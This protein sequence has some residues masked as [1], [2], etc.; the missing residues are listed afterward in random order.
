VCPCPTLENTLFRQVPV[1][2]PV[3]RLTKISLRCQGRSLVRRGF[4]DSTGDALGVP[5]GTDFRQKPTAAC[6]NENER[7]DCK[8]G[9][10]GIVPNRSGS[11]RSTGLPG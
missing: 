9:F 6:R 7:S 3:I 10:V 2:C 5:N 4:I 11:L 8:T 1:R